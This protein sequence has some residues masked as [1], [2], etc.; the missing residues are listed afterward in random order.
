MAKRRPRSSLASTILVGMVILL[1]GLGLGIS[2]SRSAPWRA[3][4]ATPTPGSRVPI[5][6][7]PL[8]IDDLALDAAVRRALSQSSTV[9]RETREELTEEDGT[10]QLRWHLLVIDV[11]ARS[12]GADP[13][14]VLGQEVERAGGKVFS[15]TPSA[16][17]LGVQREG[18]IFVTHE[19]RVLPF[20]A[21]ARVAIIFD[22][23][24]ASLEELDPIIALGRPVTVAVLPGL[25]YSRE[26]AERT[27]AAGLEVFLHL[28]LEPEDPTKRV[29]P[30][31]ITTDMSDEQIISI[32]RTDLEDVPGVVG[33][34][35]H[36]GSRATADERVM[37]AVLRVVKERDLI[38]VD[39][40]TSARSIG[41]R[42]ASEMQIRTAARQVFLDNIDEREA[43]RR[44]IV[45]L[46]ALARQ[47]GEAVAIGHAR[48]LTARVLK[49]ML[50]EF[51]RQGIELVPASALAR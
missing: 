27:R 46:I 26:A 31:A 12:S 45:R 16:I 47:R 35:N 28:P 23:A 37:R 48:R 36:M 6:T 22:D 30:G 29:G 1:L 25:R 38:F 49:D 17:R 5:P 39:S 34:N 3:T 21:Q 41:S 50:P 8:T 51:D 32:V 44:Q 40:V 14:R 10:L 13:L 42:L 43:I 18:R 2:L 20:R 15:R 7:A 9:V 33:V 19:I 24:G 11:R 4:P